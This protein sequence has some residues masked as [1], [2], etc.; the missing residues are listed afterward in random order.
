[1]GAV[2]GAKEMGAVEGAK[3][4]GAVEGA[5]AADFDDAS[6]E[7]VSIPHGLELLPAEA[8]GSINYQ[9]EAWYRKRFRVPAELAGKRLF[10]HFEAI[11]GKSKV[12]V[13]GQL[14]AE[15]FG[16]F[17]PIHL[18]LTDALDANDENVIAVWADNSDDE[19]YPPGKP[20]ERLDWTYFGG[21]YRDA[22]LIATNDLHISD[23]N[24]ASKVAGGGVFVRTAELNDSSATISISVDLANHGAARDCVIENSIVSSDG[25]T[26]GSATSDC[27]AT[28]DGAAVEQ[29]IVVERPDLWTPATPTLYELQTLV[30]LDGVIVDGVITRFGIRTID[31][32]GRDGFFLNGLPYEGKLIGGNRHQDFAYVGNALPNSMHVRDAKRL[33]DAGMTI[34]RTAHY[35]LD[36]AFMDACD[37]LGLFVIVTTPG[38]QFFNEDQLFQDRVCDD[39]RNM[40]RRDRNRPCVLMWECVLNE[41]KVSDDFAWRIHNVTHEEYPYPGCY[42]AG[43]FHRSEINREIYDVMYDHYDSDYSVDK[44]YFQREWGDCVDDFH[45]HNSP[46]RASRDWGEAAQLVQALQYADPGFEHPCLEKLHAAPRQHVGGCLWHSFDHQ[47]GY[48]PDPFWGG[49]MDAF[50]QPKYSYEMFRSQQDAGD[51]GPI[52][53]V[54][55]EMTPFSGSDVW[56]F[57]NCEEVRLSVFGKVVATKKCR[58]D[59]DAMPHPPVC[60]ENVYT[61]REIKQRGRDRWR[62]QEI[63]AEGLIG[64]EVVASFKRTPSRR[65]DRIELRLDDCD[66]PLTADGAD[67]TMVIAE[68]VDEEGVVKRLNK[69][70][71][72]FE[73]EGEGAIIGDHRIAANPRAVEWGSAPVLI[74]STTTAGSITVR[75][76]LEY[77]G[78]TTP[79][80]GAITFDSVPATTPFA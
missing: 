5:E 43:D 36:P 10:V 17:L 3:E 12:W 76:R 27:R 38:W 2:E 77:P 53:F 71:I 80:A 72:R 32:R 22:W 31:F 70:W 26:V 52:V 35:P 11:M 24:A 58:S 20:Q 40:V 30:K 7:S 44:S 57:T 25:V 75:A 4:M 15:H 42:T 59:D 6:W 74:R 16:G 78:I 63:I 55:N 41:V 18:D 45:A 21:I 34:I 29:T 79:Q 48:H 66:I 9:G 60:F 67:F 54:A 8:S 19:T 1:M 69:D 65:K 61:F 39:I 50:R 47:R 49:L 73:V 62:E 37:E 28:S 51:V 46:S 23:P 33:R 64:R 68:V 13:N 14:V 56:V